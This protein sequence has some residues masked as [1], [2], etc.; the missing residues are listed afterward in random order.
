MPSYP[1]CPHRVEAVIPLI[2]YNLLSMKIPQLSR[3]ERVRMTQPKVHAQVNVMINSEAMSP[4]Q[5]RRLILKTSFSSPD[6]PNLQ[7]GNSSCCCVDLLRV[8]SFYP[9][10]SIQPSSPNQEDPPSA[11]LIS[12]LTPKSFRSRFSRFS[13]LSSFNRLQTWSATLCAGLWAW[14]LGESNISASLSLAPQ[15]QAWV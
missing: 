8:P 12:R 1:F 9:R 11:S 4:P 14:R 5:L 10:S 2:M 6:L 15:P 13:V 3:L 7:G